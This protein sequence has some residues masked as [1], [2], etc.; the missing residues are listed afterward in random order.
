MAKL[1]QPLSPSEVPENRAHTGRSTTCL[2]KLSE[3]FGP[4]DFV[5]V[6]NPDTEDYLWQWLPPQKEHIS[7]DTSSSTVPM[8]VVYREDPET[9]KIDAG[10]S[11]TLVGANAYVM[12]D[13]LVKRMM[14]K[15]V[16]SR[17]PDVKPGQAR[18]F[19][20][21]DDQAQIEWINEIYL[22]IDN[23]FDHSEA[24]TTNRPTNENVDRQINADLGIA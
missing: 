3:M 5:K 2:M 1:L 23:P 16:V 15:R 22:G 10:Q 14:A 17:N 20:F 19:N 7:F 12:I 9:W 13:G 8:R 21:S 6:I 4:A 18:N 11:G 24:R